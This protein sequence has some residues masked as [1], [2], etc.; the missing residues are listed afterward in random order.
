MS[1]CPATAANASSIST[2]IDV[3]PL[4]NSVALV[5]Q[6]QIQT[7]LFNFLALFAKYF[8]K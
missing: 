6:V 2:D 4:L 7:R 8:H 3:S 5:V 1:E